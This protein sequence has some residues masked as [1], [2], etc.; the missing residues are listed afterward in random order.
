[1]SDS[2]LVQSLANSPDQLFLL[3]HG[4]GSNPQ[5]MVPLGELLASEFKQATVISV[6]S[7]DPCDMGSGYQWFSV[8]GI[9]EDN[10]GERIG[11]TM[12]RFA[13]TV[14]GLQKASGLTA[15]QTVL[16]GFSQ[17]AIMALE[18]TRTSDPLAGHVVSI[19]GRFAQETDQRRTATQ[20]HFIH[21]TM[22]PV[23]DLGYTVRAAE[24]LN[25]LGASVTVDLIEGLGHGID[26]RVADRVVQRLKSGMEKTVEFL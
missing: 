1:M 5:N 15:A 2:I 3:F 4:V 20:L 26:T 13:E 19:A 22:D 12:P 25:R 8:R 23:I 6:A 18:S 10:R 9:T 21:G 17:G 14:R 11:A 7:P 16:I 24:R